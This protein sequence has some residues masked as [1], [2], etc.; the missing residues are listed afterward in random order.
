MGEYLAPSACARHCRVSS[1][2]TD[3]VHGEDAISCEDK[4][5]FVTSYKVTS[6]QELV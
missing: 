1:A 4:L 2:A 3:C 5:H 6:D